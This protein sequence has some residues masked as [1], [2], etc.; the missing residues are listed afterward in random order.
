MPKFL[1]GACSPATIAAITL[2]VSGSWPHTFPFWFSSCL[3]IRVPSPFLTFAFSFIY[4]SKSL[5]RNKNIQNLKHDF[6][7][8]DYFNYSKSPLQ[9]PHHCTATLQSTPRGRRAATP[10]GVPTHASI[11]PP[12]RRSRIHPCLASKRRVAPVRRAHRNPIIFKVVNWR[13]LNFYFLN[14]GLIYS[15]FCNYL[16]K[17]SIYMI[18]MFLNIFIQSF[19]VVSLEF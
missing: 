14:H 5:H 19:Q 13:V 11:S 8:P 15:L 16:S 6:I 10:E 4:G 3:A 2:Y 18:C 12:H 1:V 17:V 9:W 7:S